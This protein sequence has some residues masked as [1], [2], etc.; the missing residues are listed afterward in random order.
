[1][2]ISF[3]YD[4][5]AGYSQSFHMCD[6]PLDA[7]QE[8]TDVI[9][10]VL[11]DYDIKVT[12]GIVGQVVLAG[13]PPEHC[14][15]QI[16]AVHKAGHEIA[17]HSMSHRFLPAMSRTQ[18]YSDVA[19]SKQA[20]ESCIG[21][22]VRGFIPPFNRPMHFPSRGAFSISEVLG[23]H[24][25]GIGRQSIETM[26]R[27]LRT[28]GFGWCRVSFENK[29]CQLMGLLGLA[30][31]NKPTQPFILY[32]MV[33]IPLHCTGFGEESR[34]F[35]R[36]FLESDLILAIYGHANQ[37]LSDNEQSAKELAGFL[38]EFNKERIKGTLQFNTMGE[39][40]TMIRGSNKKDPDICHDK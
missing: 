39:I 29:F 40:E 11:A 18:M 33:A 22:S 8:G 37:A 6:Y 5:P 9:L 17:S 38:V 15:E 34:L 1:M 7:D 24:G 14:S 10:K 26:L 4:S 16:R 23:F 25:R 31:K 30:T 21:A 13:K 12:F 2:A 27:I 20:L 3:D 35:I 32:D 19:T 28:A 36:R